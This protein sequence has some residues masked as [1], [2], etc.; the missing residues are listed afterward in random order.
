MN[1]NTRMKMKMLRG[2][3]RMVTTT[4][5]ASNQKTYL[6]RQAMGVLCVVA[7]SCWG[8]KVL[9]DVRGRIEEFKQTN[10]ENME[11]TDGGKRPVEDRITDAPFGV[12]VAASWAIARIVETL[13][14]VQCT[15]TW[16]SVWMGESIRGP[17]RGVE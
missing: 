9:V 2:E 17:W 5:V 16:D 3:M 8:R 12:G 15:S 1:L 6:R 4:I 11:G 10:D 13:I 7:G 14:G